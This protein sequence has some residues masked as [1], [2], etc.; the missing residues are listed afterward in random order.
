[1]QYSGECI[2]GPLDGKA[3]VHFHHTYH[4]V[5][6]QPLPKNINTGGTMPAK[7]PLP[8]SASYYWEGHHKEQECGK[9]VWRYFD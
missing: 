6:Q 7:L 8:Q 9:G 1:M 2:G 3:I 4:I 5:M